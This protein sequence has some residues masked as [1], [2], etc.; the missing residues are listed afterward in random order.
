MSRWGFGPTSPRWGEP[1]TKG[2]QDLMSAVAK[3]R[4]AF[5]AAVFVDADLDAALAVA[6]PDISFETIPPGHRATGI[7]DV[8]SHLAKDVLPYLPVDLTFR[9]VSRTGDRWRVAAEDIVTFTHDREL[10]WL[11]PGIA[12]TGRRAEV[13]AISVVTVRH[14][15]VT[16]HRMLWDHAA[17][18]S[19]LG[20]VDLR[21]AG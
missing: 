8:R 14:S 15:A 21:S 11:L 10:P 1:V 9:P 16:S 20:I 5:H 12:P 17:L 7:D 3:L 13:L 19:Q 2:V 18:V 6:A 4:D